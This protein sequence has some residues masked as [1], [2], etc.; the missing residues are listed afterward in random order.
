VLTRLVCHIEGL[1]LTVKAA[2]FWEQDPCSWPAQKLTSVFAEVSR[3]QNGL[4]LVWYHL[5][6]K[7]HTCTSFLRLEKGLSVSSNRLHSPTF[8]HITIL[9]EL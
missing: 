1:L 9:Y 3:Y 6:G 7:L 5:Y 2:C 8:D 4:E